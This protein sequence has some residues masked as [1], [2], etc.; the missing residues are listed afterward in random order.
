LGTGK[1]KSV[2]SRFGVAKLS[3][4][5][6]METLENMEKWFRVRVTAPKLIDILLQRYGSS[7]LGNAQIRKM[8]LNHVD[9][10]DR[11]YI[12]GTSTKVI[13]SSS[14]SGAQRLV[15]TLELGAEFLPPVAEA[16]PPASN[17]IPVSA[18]LHEYQFNVKA[19]A[20]AA[21]KLPSSRILLHMPTGAGKTRTAC[22][23]MVDAL[24]AEPPGPALIVWLAHSE[25]LCTQAVEAIER[26]WS[27]KGDHGATVTR[28]WGNFERPSNSP[29]RG[30][31]VASF[32]SIHALLTSASKD[33]SLLRNIAAATRMIVIDEAHKAIAP[34]YEIAINSLSMASTPPKLVGLSATPG[35]SD[36]PEENKALS[37][38]F[39]NTKI[40]LC[41]DDGR[42]LED[43]IGYLQDMGVLARL[44]RE[45]IETDVSIDLSES[46]MVKLSELMELPESFLRRLG[47]QHERNLLIFNRIMELSDAKRQVILFACSIAHAEL[48]SDL[49]VARNIAA[50][51]VTGQT[52]P[53]DRAR[54]IAEYKD[55]KVQLLINY[56]VL[57]TGFD[58]PNTDTVF[59]TRPTASVVLYSQMIGRAIR[60]PKN[61]GNERARVIDVVDNLHGMPSENMAYNYF[62]NVWSTQQ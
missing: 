21:L 61:G 27:S 26:S 59:I 30:F 52:D 51:L 15:Q 50:R 7:I 20:I 32:Q 39:D 45:K 54:Y 36:N 6:G 24:R 18:P 13:W 46:E 33:L 3:E 5:V 35:R 40:G 23:L 16:S 12:L 31:V 28:I 1:L 10:F 22:E 60:G 47:G 49:C 34:T 2:L 14:S 43:G 55:G 37:E 53:K 29:E 25:E 41:D 42:E 8:V 57:T 58:A 56:G 11:K 44:D 62:N 19:R 9:D 48:L 4:L 17:S 38:F